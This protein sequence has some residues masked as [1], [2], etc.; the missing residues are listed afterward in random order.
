MAV[1]A[2]SPSTSGRVLA[3]L[4][5]AVVFLAHAALVPVHL[6]T[7]HV[8]ETVHEHEHLHAAGYHEGEEHHHDEEHHGGDHDGS[9]HLLEATPYPYPGVEFSPA[10]ALAAVVEAAEERLQLARQVGF[11]GAPEE[12][13]PRPPP[14]GP[15]PSRAPPIG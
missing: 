12:A 14:G 3:A 15:A 6:V 8:G 2:S 5:A 11:L 13:V 9:S 4:C 10:P 7:Q 1:A